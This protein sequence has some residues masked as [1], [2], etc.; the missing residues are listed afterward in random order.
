MQKIIALLNHL[1]TGISLITALGVFVHD[2]RVDKAATTIV[3]GQF[4]ATTSATLSQRY[5][6]FASS[7]AHTHPDHNAARASL[8]N[9]FAYQSPSIP[10]RGQEDKRHLLKEI[11]SRGHFAFDNANL[12]YIS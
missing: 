1:M 7:D 10:P 3:Y 12:P 2:S 6:D 11:R 5:Q 4:K 9:H 8:L